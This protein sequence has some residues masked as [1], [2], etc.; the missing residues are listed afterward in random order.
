MAQVRLGSLIYFLKTQKFQKENIVLALP[1]ARRLR[2][3][4]LLAPPPPRLVIVSAL[5]DYS[6]S[7]PRGD[8]V[9]MVSAVNKQ[10]RL[11]I[12]P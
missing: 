7:Y 4:P 3:S 12:Q 5:H 6:C 2:E 11:E 9:N 8:Y 10:A 1:A